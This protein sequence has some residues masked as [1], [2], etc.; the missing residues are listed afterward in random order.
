MRYLIENE[1][2][3]I[4]CLIR[5]GRTESAEKRLKSM[6][7]FYFD[8]SYDEMFESGR[9][10]AVDG[11]ITDREI[12]L[13]QK[14]KSFDTVINCAAC[15]KHFAKDD[16]LTRVNVTGVKNLIE[17]CQAKDA[18]LVQISTV[19]VAG[20]NV[21]HALDSAVMFE[22]MLYFGQDLSNQY[23]RSKYDAEEAVLM[24]LAEGALKA[25]I[26][27]VGNLMSRNSD[28]EFQANAI[29]SGFMRN[30][31]GYAVVGAYPISGMARPVEFSPIDLVAEAVCKLAKTPEQFTVFHAV[32]GHWIEMGDLIAVMNDVGIHVEVVSDDEFQKRLAEAMQ[33][34]N[35]NMLVSGLIS[36]L[37]SDTDTVRS[38][39]PE[40][41]T[42][43][44]N[45]LYRMGY[46]WPLTDE[47]YL[48]L[49]MNALITLGFFDG[50]LE[51]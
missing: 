14:D 18:R 5:K 51:G 11:D 38:Y 23:V 22:N 47:N 15:V 33:D 41:H 31:R 50:A 1:D 17:L 48:K 10:V 20:E 6:L 21:N 8:T 39:I 34:E 35:K 42:F 43:T 30:L 4:I 46:R 49:A 25:K 45:V 3:N 9:I 36:Y 12:V 19:S 40:D 26:I 27:R 7:M 2:C 29:T 32:N 28:G 13:A 16:I 24:E 37:S 44:K